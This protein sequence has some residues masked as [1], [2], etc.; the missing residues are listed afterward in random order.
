MNNQLNKW[1]FAAVLMTLPWVGAQAEDY[2]LGVVNV[3]ALLEKALE[4]SGVPGNLERE[5]SP[6]DKKLV[7]QQAEIQTM[8]DKLERDTAVMSDEGRR[9]LERDI[10]SEKRDLKR[11]STEFREDV[12]IR[13][14]ELLAKI[15]KNVMAVIKVVAKDEKFDMIFGE[16]VVFGAARVDVT[17]SIL[18][19]YREMYGK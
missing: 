7:A 4:I 5:F 2:K 9:K 15:Q 1:I 17:K 10:Q 8:E 16:G 13:K 6:R 3:Q 14:N 11:A 18:G 19:R 12:N